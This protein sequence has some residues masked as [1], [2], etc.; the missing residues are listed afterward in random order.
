M[1]LLALILA[2]ALEQWRP[3]ADRRYLFAPVA[4]YANWLERQFNAGQV[5]H[6]AIAWCLAVLPAVLGAALVHYVLSKLHPLLSIAFSVVVLYF[7]MGFRQFSH[8]YTDI[9]LALQADDL[10]RARAQLAAWR[11]H[12]CSSLGREDVVR[13][14]IEEALS[15]SHRR[16][17]GVVFWFVLLPGPAGAVLYRLSSMLARRWGQGDQSELA[18]FGRFARDA[19]A[20]IDWLPVRV[21]AAAFAV[22]GDFEDAVF[23]WRGQASRWA[24]PLIGVVLAAGAGAIGVRLGGAYIADGEPVDR[25]E[26]GVGDEPDPAFLDSTIGLVWRT[27]SLLVALLALLM[28]ASVFG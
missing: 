28:I 25:P 11:G 21:T 5:Q 20:A 24:D 13:L 19:F 12:D 1:A 16:V 7:T 18:D 22:V 23:C 8:F 26:I 9:R 6:G 15:A 3:L 10:D 2:L 17:F 27:V 4:R 14:A